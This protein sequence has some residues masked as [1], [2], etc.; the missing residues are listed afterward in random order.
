M[1]ALDDVVRGGSAEAPITFAAESNLFGVTTDASGRR[2]K[3]GA[4]PQ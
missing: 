3:S 4:A 1:L 2:G